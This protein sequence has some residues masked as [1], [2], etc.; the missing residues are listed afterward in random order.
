MIWTT[1]PWTLPGNRAVSFS[2]KIK[3]GLY[4]VTDAAPENWAKFGDLFILSDNLAGEVFKQARVLA[5]DRVADVSRRSAC[6]H[7]VASIR[8]R[9]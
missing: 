5:Y 6:G 3:Y 4:K 1:T 2:S 8:L 9:G 7:D